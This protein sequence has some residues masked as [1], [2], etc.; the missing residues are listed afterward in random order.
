MEEGHDL[1][2][3]AYDE[4]AEEEQEASIIDDKSLVFADPHTAGVRDPV[5]R[6]LLEMRAQERQHH[7][8]NVRE[9]REFR[10]D[11]VDML[12][13]QHKERMDAMHALI[14]AIG[15]QQPQSQPL[16]G[17]IKRSSTFRPPG[18]V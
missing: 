16:N 10:R 12:D 13:R 2:Q 8:E 3:D 4:Y 18:D 9:Q 5:I 11:L 7:R 6:L 1:N 14:S 17:R 15:G